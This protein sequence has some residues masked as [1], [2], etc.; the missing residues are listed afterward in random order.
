VNLTQQGHVIF[1]TWFTYDGS[2]NP[3]WLSG[4]AVKMGAGVY[5]GTLAQT[6]GPGFDAVPFDPAQV[7]ETPV[8]TYTLRFSDGANGTFAYTVNG[9]AQTKA[10]TREVFVSPGTICQ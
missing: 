3:L 6:A 8:G 9:V 10:I 2:G 7:V 1:A 4:P 5:T